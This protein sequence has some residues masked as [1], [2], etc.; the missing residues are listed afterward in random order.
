MPNFFNKFPKHS[1]KVRDS[2]SGNIKEISLTDLLRKFKLSDLAL[3][4]REAFYKYRWKESD[5]VDVVSDKYYDSVD[6]Y[7]L[8]MMSNE[9]F[10]MLHDFPLNGKVFDRYIIQKYKED[11]I[12][13]GF[14]EDDQNILEYVKTTIKHYYDGDDFIIDQDTHSDLS[15]P[16]K[17]SITIYDW[18]IEQNELKR[19][20]SLLSDTYAPRVKTELEN[21]LRNVR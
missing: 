4:T 15:D 11:A 9:F 10:D 18:E 21:K 3:E 1:F 17:S 16:D 14:G 12:D 13:A 19:E 8:V 7:W 5:R 6:F 2:K 20:I